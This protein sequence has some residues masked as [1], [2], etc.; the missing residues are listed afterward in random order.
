MSK[1]SKG[2]KV[3]TLLQEIAWLWKYYNAT[4]FMAI[5]RDPFFL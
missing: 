4:V 3:P 5:S 2:G 1:I